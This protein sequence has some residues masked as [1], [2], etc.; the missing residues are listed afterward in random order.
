M[1]RLRG[2][3]GSLEVFANNLAYQSEDP[4]PTAYAGLHTRRRNHM[5]R[6]SSLKGSCSRNRLWISKRSNE[7][8]N[9][10]RYTIQKECSRKTASQALQI[11]S[12]SCILRSMTKRKTLFWRKI[13]SFWHRIPLPI[14]MS[15]TKRPTMPWWWCITRKKPWCTQY[16][17]TKTRWGTSIQK[18]WFRPSKKT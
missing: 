18:A 13:H 3:I 2:L 14:S 4:T 5:I 10:I 12:P 8:L 17:S 9:S 11:R 7:W 16:C 1:K 6:I 15:S